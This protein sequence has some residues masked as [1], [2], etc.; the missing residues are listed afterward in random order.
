MKTLL[1]VGSVAFDSI[2]TIYGK[3]GK[4]LGGAG[5]YISIAASFFDIKNNLISIVGGDFPQEFLEVFKA[6]NI[7]ISGIEIKKDKKTF[8]WAGRYEKN[9]NIRHTLITELNV[10][11]EFNPKVPEN[12]K[13]PDVLML[14]NL[15]PE[16]QSSVIKQ[17]S[18][19][20]KLIVMDTM[21]FWIKNTNETLLNTISMIDL[22]MVNDEEIRL[23]TNEYFLP[24][25]AKKVFELGPR[26][27]V[28]KKGDNGA[29]LFTKAGEVFFAPAYPLENVYD[30]TGAGDTF[31]GA[32]CG[33][34]AQTGDFSFENMKNAIIAASA[35][36]SFNVEKF[37][38]AR[39]LS[40]NKS[41]ILNRIDDFKRF[42]QF[43]F[44][45]K[46]F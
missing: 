45:G 26:F 29:I 20:P 37:G 1:T 28:I 5:T 8:F 38:T 46:I 32:F 40:L 19:R 30:P 22:L 6:K 23:L 27:V 39:L 42:T 43:D 33:Y 7:D 16:E 14:G 34:L 17:L 31:A 11:A 25:A 44:P 21:D 13:T 35:L 10:L 12:F 15:S 2:E 36:A 41:E 9:M 3:S 4:I 18:K 24:R